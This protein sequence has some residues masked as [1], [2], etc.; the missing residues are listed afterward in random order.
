MK[1]ALADARRHRRPE[2]IRTPTAQT[3]VITTMTG[4]G[5]SRIEAFK[6]LCDRWEKAWTELDGDAVAQ[7]CAED[8]LYDEPAL[9]DTRRG[10]EAVRRHVMAMARTFPDGT[11]SFTRI[12]LY[13]EVDRP[14]MVV[15]WQFQGTPIGTDRLIEFHGDDRL[16][17]GEDGLIHAYRGL[18]DNRLV[19]KLLREAYDN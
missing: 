9:E 5:T 13:I 7:L 10:R 16:E 6:V 3:K 8:L 17:I 12:G 15:A 19:R 4:D 14:A 1:F 2:I 18:Y 11:S